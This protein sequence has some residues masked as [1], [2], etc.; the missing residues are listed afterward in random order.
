M[1]AEFGVYLKADIVGGSED[2]DVIDIDC[3]EDVEGC[4]EVD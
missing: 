3:K 4:G 2:Q 1:V